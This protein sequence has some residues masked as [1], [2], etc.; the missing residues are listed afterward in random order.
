MAFNANFMKQ[1]KLTFPIYTEQSVYFESY[2]TGLKMSQQITPL[3]MRT[4]SGDK[5]VFFTFEVSTK[6]C[7]GDDLQLENRRHRLSQ[8]G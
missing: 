8:A 5:Q 6:C 7:W 1:G 2:V 4:F 3:V